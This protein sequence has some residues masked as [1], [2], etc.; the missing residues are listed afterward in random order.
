MIAEAAPAAKSKVCSLP[1]RPAAVS[2]AFL[3][4]DAKNQVTAPDMSNAPST[5]E[6]SLEKSIRP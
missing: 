1:S 3:Y 2:G 4:W 6:M 5:R